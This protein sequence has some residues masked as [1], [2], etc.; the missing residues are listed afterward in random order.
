MIVYKFVFFVYYY[1]FM[2]ISY[3]NIFLGELCRDDVNRSVEV[4]WKGRNEKGYLVICSLYDY[5]WI[6]CVVI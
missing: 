3:V 2:L 4:D 6:L 5:R 1:F